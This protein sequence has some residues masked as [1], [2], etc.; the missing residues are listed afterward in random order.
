LTIAPQ[1]QV[2]VDESERKTQAIPPNMHAANRKNYRVNV[3]NK[4]LEHFRLML[5]QNTIQ[6]T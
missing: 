2:R 1:N 5:S 3:M 6:S 4:G